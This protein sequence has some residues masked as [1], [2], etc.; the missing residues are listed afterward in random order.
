M[1]KN[2]LKLAASAGLV[3]ISTGAW[4]NPR[5]GWAIA[6]GICIIAAATLHLAA[7]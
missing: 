3:L 6:V 7:P 2:T 4:P 1:I 5:Y